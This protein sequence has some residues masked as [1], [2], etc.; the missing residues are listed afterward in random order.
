MS[1]TYATCKNETK[2]NPKFEIGYNFAGLFPQS[3]TFRKIYK[4]SPT[5]AVETTF[6]LPKN[7][8]LW[9]NFLYLSKDGRSIPVEDKTHIEIMP[10]SLGFKYNIALNFFDFSLGL[11]P[12]YTWLRIKD[13]SEFVNQIV[14]KQ[15]FGAMFKSS[16]KY[17]VKKLYFSVFLDYFF[18]HFHFPTT[19]E[20]IKRHSTDVGGLLLGF[21]IGT[22]F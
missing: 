13:K 18:Q 11:G 16:I 15:N 4:V 22:N 8:N 14:K 10:L 2:K 17:R 1:K 9:V 3:P 21:G 19:N 12:C 7:F 5:N 6:F 20:R